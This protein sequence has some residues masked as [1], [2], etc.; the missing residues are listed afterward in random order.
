MEL[1]MSEEIP[2]AGAPER[3]G[4][5]RPSRRRWLVAVF[6]GAAALFGFAAGKVH[7]APWWHLA[8]HHHALDAEEID[9][10]VEHRVNRLLSKVDATQEQRDKVVRIVKAAVNDVRALRK[11]PWDQREKFAGLLRADTIDRAALENL[12]AEQL[13][14]ADAATKRLLQAVADAAEVL[15]PEQR[16]QLAELWEHRHGRW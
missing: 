12:R 9:Y 4:G 15:T 3:A 5:S 16:R 10:L 1:C 6:A 8:G 2:T 11:G 14:T 7:S 13:S